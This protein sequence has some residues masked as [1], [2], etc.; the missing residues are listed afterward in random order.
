MTATTT[1]TERFAPPTPEGVAIPTHP[2]TY[3]GTGGRILG[4]F[5]SIAV[6]TR[7]RLNNLY[8]V[9]S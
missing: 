9:L 2:R 5:A 8:G 7:C 4:P 6:N 3:R 1:S